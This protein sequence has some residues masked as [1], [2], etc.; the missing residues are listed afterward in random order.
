[1]NEAHRSLAA[2]LLV[3]ELGKLPAVKKI[4]LVQPEDGHSVNLVITVSRL[5][6]AGELPQCRAI[7]L[8]RL[9]AE[10]GL[11][12][13]VRQV[14]M[15]VLS[16]EGNAYLGHVSG[17]A[18]A[19]KPVEGFH[20]DPNQWRVLY[21]NPPKKKKKKG[22]KHDPWW[23]KAKKLCR[24]N[25]EEIR[26]AKELGMGPRAILRNIPSPKQQW[27]LPVKLWI[28]E[29]YEKRHPGKGFKTEPPYV[30]PPPLSPEEEEFERHRL[31]EEMYWKDYRDGKFLDREITDN[32]VPF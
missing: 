18:S 28:R 27:K 16:V 31:E 14:N 26:M 2:E 30:P 6:T 17:D 22:D 10:R 25:Q 8:D 9:K 23:V 21:R 11:D 15:A 1:M 5:E 3:Q 29:L 19:V 24:L 20:F 12:V 13:D 7:A 4:S 32:D